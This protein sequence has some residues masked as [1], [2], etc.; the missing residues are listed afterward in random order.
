M[1]KGNLPKA[2]LRL[3]P[4]I[5][6]AHPDPGAMV[7]IICAANRQP[8]RGRFKNRSLL[9]AVLGRQ[10][11]K[12][13]LE[14]GDL[15]ALD[16]GRYFVPGWDE[17]QEGDWTVGE[18]QRRIRERRNAG[19]VTESRSESD[20]G[21]TGTSPGRI[22]TPRQQGS[23]AARQQ[24][25]LAGYPDAPLD[26]G[27]EYPVLAWLAT[28]GASIAPNGNGYHRRVV[29]LVNRFGPEKV[30]QAMAGAIAAGAQGD[31]AIVFGAENLLDPPPS[32]KQPPKP[33]GFNPTSD[34]AWDAFGGRPDVA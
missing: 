21:T 10:L 28:Q 29:V 26:D 12:A 11:V 31:R 34:E 3:D 19:N 1:T 4:N 22:P 23:K 30:R 24:G 25:A 14:R 33:K 15:V 7:R 9:D 8:H 32:A 20:T 6:H 18:R 5:D 2:Y 16:D 27:P 17:W 13:A